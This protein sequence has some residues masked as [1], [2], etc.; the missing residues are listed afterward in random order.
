M[1]FIFIMILA[2]LPTVLFIGALVW[3]FYYN[4]KRTF[5]VNDLRRY[6]GWITYQGVEY[7]IQR[8]ADI[9]VGLGYIVVTNPNGE[10][11]RFTLGNAFTQQPVVR[12]ERW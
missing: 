10:R 5:M 4:T 11:M 3:V 9:Q 7:R 2:M 1:D 12:I 6:G 8:G